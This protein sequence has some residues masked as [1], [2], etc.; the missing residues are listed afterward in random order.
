MEIRGPRLLP[1]RR[2]D[3]ELRTEDGLRLVGE[4]ALPEAGEPVATLVTLHPLP[5]AGGFMDSHI[6]RK[7]AARLPALADL[8]VLRFNTRGT[9]SPR[10]ASEGVFDGGTSERLD[11]AAAMAFVHERG[12]PRPWLVG[13][14]FGTEL[15]LKYGR[16]HDIEG[17]I[18]LSPPLHRATAAEVAAWAQDDRQVVVL[19]P[20]LDDYLRPDEATERFAAIPHAR[21]IAVDGGRHLW[22]GESQTRRVLDEIV[23]A[24]NPAAL[25]LRREWP[26]L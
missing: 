8:A 21:L 9:S 18:L 5:T 2:E 14:S 23:S 24:V 7:A 17:V 1:A 26:A 15:A 25:P 13:W 12:L 6:L 4:L 3:I 10:G 19:V 16:Q 11:V 20:E 22:V